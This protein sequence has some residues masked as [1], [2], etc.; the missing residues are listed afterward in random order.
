MSDGRKW[1]LRIQFDCREFTMSFSLRILLVLLAACALAPQAR[2][3]VLDRHVITR[4]EGQWYFQPDPKDVGE[5]EGWANPGRVR[6]RTIPVPTSW[7][8]VFEDLR[9]YV[10]T[11]WYEREFSIP[12]DVRG[13]R[14]AIQFMGVDWGAKFFVNG[15]PA[16]QHE[17]AFEPF[18]VDITDLVNYGE[19]NTLTIKVWDFADTSLLPY[20]SESAFLRMSGIWRGAW[21]EVTGKTYVSDIFVKPDID[22]QSAEVELEVAA[23]PARDYRY[24]QLRTTAVAPDGKE[25]FSTVQP[26]AIA[27]AT[28]ITTVR[29][30]AIL[31]IENPVLWDLDH[32]ELYKMTATVLDGAKALD[33]ASTDF[34]MRK[35]STWG[36][37]IL[38]NNKPIYLSGALDFVD[39]PDRNIY[40]NPYHPWTEEEMKSE[41]L[42]WKAMGFNFIRKFGIE[43]ERYIKLCDRLGVLIMDEPTYFNA[44]NPETM[45]RWEKMYRALILRDRNHPSV[46]IWDMFNE[47]GGFG[48]DPSNLRKYYEM[49]KSLDPTRPIIDNSGGLIHISSNNPPGNHPITDIEDIHYYY[50]CG[51]EWYPHSRD[52]LASIEARD[53]PVLLTELLALTYPPDIQRWQARFGGKTP[54]WFNLPSLPGEP[55]GPLSSNTYE[56]TWNAWKLDRVF[57]N[58]ANFARENEWRA[59]DIFKYEIEQM[60]KN[61]NIVGFTYT[62]MNQQPGQGPVGILGD[63]GFGDER[64]FQ[65]LMPMVNNQDIVFVDWKRVNYWTTEFF[66]A[67]VVFSHYGPPVKDA[68]LKY[69]LE[70]FGIGG[71][72]DGVTLAEPGV[73]TIGTIRFRV[74]DV[75]ESCKLKLHIVLEQDGRTVARN[76]MNVSVFPVAW[77]K[78]GISPV[79]LYFPYRATVGD[80]L[81][82]AVSRLGMAGIGAG[83]GMDPKVNPLMLTTVFDDTIKN[84]ATNG[85]TVLLLVRDPL[86][87]GKATG[88]IIGENVYYVGNGGW[89][90]FVDRSFPLFKRIPFQNLLDWQFYRIYSRNAIGGF[91]PENKP[92]ILAAGYGPWFFDTEI[93]MG[94]QTVRGQLAATIAQFKLGEGRIVITTMPLIEAIPADPVATIVL[95]DLL[96]YCKTDFKPVMEL[97]IGGQLDAKVTTSTSGPGEAKAPAQH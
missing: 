50:G 24:L 38:L 39:Y 70:G 28:S 85:G 79:G 59:F 62:Q 88:L 27:P 60:R 13:R 8:V 22:N 34:G 21:I 73:K 86:A 30:T 36:S 93:S 76:F 91:K 11:A 89:P 82:V 55:P 16:G 10:G 94:P 52:Y 84:Y 33:K 26:L 49:T 23:P 3:A 17:G 40:L 18:A 61:P 37:Q 15:K 29:A 57:G 53:K 6:E 44:Y 69:T 25:V 47:G 41:L 45:R 67:D 4:L 19:K 12:A 54:W 35:I 46:I 32:P 9:R 81:I 71:Q 97:P 90:V 48:G 77:M 80:D 68:V 92:D 14:V 56:Q 58:F 87:T 63:Y 31:K 66:S 42:R 78:D 20:D 83:G 64:V 1:V 75:N 74:P 43:D 2:A 95:Q 51:P 96:K 72:I 65:S 7:Q 5:S